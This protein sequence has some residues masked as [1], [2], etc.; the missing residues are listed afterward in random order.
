LSGDSKKG[1]DGSDDLLSELL[2]LSDSDPKNSKGGVS[3][4]TEEQKESLQAFLGVDTSSGVDDTDSEVRPK[5]FSEAESD[6]QDRTEAIKAPAFS[7]DFFGVVDD[8][9][10]TN[11]PFAEE[12]PSKTLVL[13]DE[14]SEESTSALEPAM[15]FV[16][17]ESASPGRDL[18][19]ISEDTLQEAFGSPI[20]PD[21]TSLD[22][23]ILRPESASPSFSPPTESLSSGSEDDLDPI[24]RALREASATTGNVPN[25]SKEKLEDLQSAKSSLNVTD[26]FE[27]DEA[28][29]PSQTAVSE[30]DFADV[31]HSGPIQVPGASFSKT[32][33]RKAGFRLVG[34]L[35]ASVLVLGGVTWTYFEL[36]SDEGL[37]GY[38]IEAWSVQEAYRPPTEVDSKEFELVFEKVD[39]VFDRDEPTKFLGLVPEL[40]AIVLKDSRNYEA[41]Q[42]LMETYGR[43]MAWEGV[44][45]N[46][47][48]AFDK[49]SQESAKIL[50]LLT[51]QPDQEISIRASAW[52]SLALSDFS[53][54]IRALESYSQTKPSL[55]DSS[56]AL[57]AELLFQSGDLTQAKNWVEQ[58]KFP[59]NNQ[60]AYYLKALIEDNS[61]EMKVLAS[62][63][64]LPAQISWEIRNISSEKDSERAFKSLDQL[65]ER[66]TNYPWLVMQVL[67]ARGDLFAS[68]KQSE[69]ARAEWK[70]ITEGFSQQSRIWLKLAR[71]FRQDNLWDESLESYRSAVRVGGL[72]RALA[73]EFVELLRMRLKVNEAFEVLEA[74]EKL[75]PKA[76][77]LRYEKGLVQLSVYQ[78]EMARQTFLETLEI[79]PSYEPAILSL[80]QIAMNQEE[81]EEAE[82]LFSRIPDSSSN[83]SKALSGRGQLARSQRDFEEAQRFF[84][85]AIRVDGKNEMAYVDLVELLL[86]KEDDQRAEVIVQQAAGLMPNSPWTAYIQAKLARFR[87]RQ[88][89]A[90][91]TL[92]SS[93]K[94]HS[95]LNRLRL[96]QVH[97]LIDLNRFDEVEQILNEMAS[98]E[99]ESSD[100]IF[101]K[102]RF[103]FKDNRAGRSGSQL[104]LAWRTTGALVQRHPDHEDYLLLRAE[105]AKAR[106]E[107]STAS[108]VVGRVN[109][110]Y[111]DQAKA[112]LIQGDLATEQG[113]FNQALTFYE[114]AKKRTRFRG[115]IFR[116]LGRL[117]QAQGDT[118][119]AVSNY[120]QVVKWFPNDSEAHLELG[121][122]YNDQGRY[123]PAIALLKRAI[124]IRP[125]HP[126]SYFYLGF[127][128]KETGNRRAA[129]EQFET[130]LKLNPGG[131]EAAT[132]RDEVF[133]LKQTGVSN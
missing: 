41:L 51:P 31:F 125:Q 40:E 67:E 103:A 106:G 92:E 3:D 133:F 102:A 79:N 29:E 129:L 64:Y 69:N 113:N 124:E 104:D 118:N 16:S 27:V 26:L 62:K 101:A 47:A 108:E 54:G 17:D 19:S 99:T 85:R 35:V 111:P 91:S 112:Y 59:S 56:K 94:T 1:G 63:D 24:D 127:I 107:R 131:V 105:I 128:Y 2:G 123:Q 83:Q 77:E 126:E 52:R 78:E 90:L 34:S 98:N 42:R 74:A 76:E 130:F 55:S 46:H 28:S 120:E 121:R 61:N 4:R 70:K 9:K 97:A 95:H 117:Y 14:E 72:Q 15:S 32:Q 75:F 20:D 96:L 38:R 49:W 50:P 7:D 57:L 22:G 66:A 100:H 65:Q 82:E 132:I 114:E 11:N 88:T 48:I 5:D 71:S 10:E 43:L 86:R 6:R 122:L 33:R 37:A 30:K 39:E 53:A 13:G 36:K 84:A 60:R 119:R 25:L 45:G 68:L 115:E 8:P 87:G 110:L 116:S 81:F 80:A 89:A 21:E 12:A 44:S 23:D 93:L 18:S 109:R 58:V 73:K